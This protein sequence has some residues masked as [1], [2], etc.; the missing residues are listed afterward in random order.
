[1]SEL[2]CVSC[3]QAVGLHAMLV[4]QEGP[5]GVVVSGPRVS[6]FGR[7]DPGWNRSLAIEA[8]RRG[9]RLELIRLGKD[10]KW[11]G[12]QFFDLAALSAAL[13]KRPKLQASQNPS[14]ALR[15]PEPHR[16]EPPDDH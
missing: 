9:G 6:H 12:E 1:M 15:P 11:T 4:W 13:D 5:G 10:Y 8:F 3:H 7:C 2:L 14:A 16:E